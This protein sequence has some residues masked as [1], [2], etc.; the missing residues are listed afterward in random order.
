[1]THS[2]SSENKKSSELSLNKDKNPGVNRGIE[3][4]LNGGKRKQKQPFHI[5]F[6]KMVCFLNREVNIYFEFSFNSKKKKRVSRGKKN[7]S[8]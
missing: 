5:I 6:E 8:S 7:V 1:M 4:M 2:D 3:L